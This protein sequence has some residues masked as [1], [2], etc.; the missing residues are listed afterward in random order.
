ME[1]THK[2]KTTVDNFELISTLLDFSVKNSFYFIQVLKRRKENPTLKKNAI[3]INIYYLYSETDLFKLKDRIIED[4]AVNNARAYISLNRLDAYLVGLYT[5]K[6]IIEHMIA[7]QFFAI[8]NAYT[9][10]CGNYHSDK[11]NTKWLIDIDIVDTNG[12][13][14]A[15]QVELSRKIMDTINELHEECRKK[16][17]KILATIPTKNGHHIITNPFNSK[18]FGDSYPGVT[19]LKNSPT[20]LYI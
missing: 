20:V 3:T 11:D 1:I 10:A 12:D 17:Y 16:N 19:F 7:G 18:K 9:T 15:T 4:C 8:K 13:I 6:I 5:Q 14:D 2:H